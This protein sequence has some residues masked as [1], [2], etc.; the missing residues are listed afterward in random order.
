MNNQNAAI[1]PSAESSC[2]LPS[3]SLASPWRVGVL[4]LGHA[5]LFYLES[6]SLSADIRLVGAFDSDPQR[7]GLATGSGCPLFD[8]RDSLLSPTVADVVFLV[9]DFS[10]EVAKAVLRGG[11]HLVIDRPWSVSSEVLR[12]LCALAATSNRTLTVASPGRWSANFVSVM[13][14]RRTGRLGNL[15]SVRLTSCEKQVPG[16]ASADGVLREFGYRWLDQ[17]LVLVDSM[18]ERVYAK[19]LSDGGPKQE[20]GFLA[21]IDFA[22]GC[23]AQIEIDAR[24]RLG[25]RTGWMIEGSTG[26]FRNDRLYTETDDGEI[27]DE[28]L[29][30]SNYSNETFISEL[31]TKWS[32]APTTLPTL[33]DAANVVQ[34][35]E[36]LERSAISGE[37]VRV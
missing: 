17:L 29:I 21:V 28:P 7:R 35:I 12:S 4:G 2:G 37:V 10:E 15:H 13:N 19:L 30:Q 20:Y 23:T 32:G 3:S 6:L 9:D 16:E 26:S 22:N 11:Q 1:P 5:G 31:T 14:A 33:A 25:F 34:V 8:Q 27:V 36:A 18:P 24:S